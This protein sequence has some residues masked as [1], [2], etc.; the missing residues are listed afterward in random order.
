MDKPICVMKFGGSSVSDTER[1]LNVAR[2]IKEKSSEFFPVVV[3]SAM[4]KT[5]DNLIKMAYS[6]T[7]E[8]PPRELDMLLTA[9]ERISMALLSMALNEMGLKAKSFTGSQVGIITEDR[10]N[11]AR[12]LEVKLLRIKESIEEGV[13]PV[14]AGFQGVSISKEITTLGR[15][16]SDLTAIALAISLGNVRCEIY[17]DVNG[18]YS[19]DPRKYPNARRYERISFETLLEMSSAGAKVMHSRAVSLA[20]K[21]NLS[22]F[23]LSSFEP[24]KGGTMV[25]K[26]LESPGVK[27]IAVKDVVMF[28]VEG[29]EGEYILNRVL[30][31]GEIIGFSHDSTG[32]HLVFIADGSERENLIR[33]FSESRFRFFVRDNLKMI[34]LVGWGV[35]SS[36]EILEILTETLKDEHIFYM[37]ITDMRISVVVEGSKERE[38]VENLAKR[39]N[40]LGG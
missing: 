27:G 19:L 28:D 4:G 22:F 25:G 7:A 12:V 34:S 33:V 5:T 1:I 11:K 2:I 21:Y 14:I 39:F 8:P 26:F 17:T 31:G 32:Q 40:L 36:R 38:I 35:G 37:N 30:K 23:V 20:A 16:G 10:F 6:I 18:I 13:I 29:K 24:K 15:G 3:V 9:G